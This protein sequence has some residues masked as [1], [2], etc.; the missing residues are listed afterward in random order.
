MNYLYWTVHTTP[1]L[2]LWAGSWSKVLRFLGV[3]TQGKAVRRKLIFFNWLLTVIGTGCLV[4][5]R[6]QFALRGHQLYTRI[7][8]HIFWYTP[9][10]VKLNESFWNYLT[11][12]K[13]SWKKIFGCASEMWFL[14]SVVEKGKK[15]KKKTM[16]FKYSSRLLIEDN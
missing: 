11:A 5:E 8:W 4:F 3:H 2:Q 13:M 7:E 6:V 9:Y 14:R 16:F 10:F 12:F 15:N 1:Q